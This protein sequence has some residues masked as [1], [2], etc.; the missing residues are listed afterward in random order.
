M[1]W[2]ELHRLSSALFANTFRHAV[3]GT[4]I[5]MEACFRIIKKGDA[6]TKANVSAYA[7]NIAMSERRS[8][9]VRAKYAERTDFLP[10]P[11]YS[12]KPSE[13][14][15]EEELREFGEQE[16][17]LIREAWENAERPYYGITRKAKRYTAC[18]C[19]FVTA[20]ISGSDNGRTHGKKTTTSNKE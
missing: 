1:T 8:F 6:F 7:R 4:D 18:V 19:R 10:T 20:R 14:P 17:K 9:A 2:N 11:D 12:R 5:V 13:P 16:R 3:Q 15:S